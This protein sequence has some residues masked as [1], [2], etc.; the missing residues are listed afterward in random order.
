M[1][2]QCEERYNFSNCIGSMN[3]K[4]IEIKQPRNSGSY[5]FNLNIPS[6]ILTIMVHIWARI[7]KDGQGKI[8]GRQPLKNLKVHGLLKS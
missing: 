2:R 7:F 8:C 3:S 4:P 6:L 5:Y 1:A